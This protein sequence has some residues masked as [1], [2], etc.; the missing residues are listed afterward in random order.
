[1]KIIKMMI[2]RRFKLIKKKEKEKKKMMMMRSKKKKMRS[3]KMMMTIKKMKEKTTLMMVCNIIIAYLKRKYLMKKNNPQ[4]TK[5]PLELQLPQEIHLLKH[6]LTALNP[7]RKQNFT[8]SSVVKTPRIN[9][10]K[11]NLQQSSLS[12]N[13]KLITLKNRNRVRT[14]V[15]IHLQS[16]KENHR[17]SKNQRNRYQQL[18]NYVFLQ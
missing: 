7:S 5:I 1:M 14:I 8:P 18:G 11:I 3:K 10:A 4:Q 9:L 15:L 2:L 12:Q 6:Y 16:S 13:R 17:R